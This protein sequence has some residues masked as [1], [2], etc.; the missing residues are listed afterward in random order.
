MAF[1]LMQRKQLD[2][3]FYMAF[4]SQLFEK[5]F[6]SWNMNDNRDMTSHNFLMDHKPEKKNSRGSLK[7]E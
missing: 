1:D 6:M 3:L 2:E 7:M 4:F 5:I